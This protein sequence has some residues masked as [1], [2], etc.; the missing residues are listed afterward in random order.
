MVATESKNLEENVAITLDSNTRSIL[1]EILAGS[2]GQGAL[3][4]M[5]SHDGAQWHAIG[6]PITYDFNVAGEQAKLVSYDDSSESFLQKL[7]VV[8]LTG[9]A[10]AKIFF[11]RSK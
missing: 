11:G 5:T 9:N 1:I 7:K 8:G 10:T 4:L 3:Q 2:D 6:L